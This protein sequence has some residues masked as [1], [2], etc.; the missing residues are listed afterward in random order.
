MRLFRRVLDSCHTI[1]PS[2]SAS[3]SFSSRCSLLMHYLP[4]LVSDTDTTPF[5]WEGH[6]ILTEHLLWMKTF[7]KTLQNCIIYDLPLSQE[8]AVYLMRQSECDDASL[9]DTFPEE[10][11]GITWSEPEAARDGGIILAA[12]AF[13]AFHDYDLRWNSTHSHC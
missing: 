4:Y 1:K 9:R 11:I 2:N 7:L 8:G 10:L 12:Y 5:D 6:N 13:K 3:S